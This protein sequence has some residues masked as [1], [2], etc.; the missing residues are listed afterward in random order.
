[1]EPTIVKHRFKNLGYLF[2]EGG[3]GRAKKILGFL[4][5]KNSLGDGMHKVA[6]CDCFWEAVYSQTWAQRPP[7]ESEKKY[8]WFEYFFLNSPGELVAGIH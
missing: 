6:K 4:M 2:W 8:N 7:S 5:L 3:G 1:M